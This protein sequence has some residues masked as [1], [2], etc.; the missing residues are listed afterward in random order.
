MSR[1]LPLSIILLAVT[2]CGHSPKSESGLRRFL[3]DELVEWM[4][5]RPSDAETFG[6]RVAATKP[7]LGY[8]IRSVVPIEPDPVVLPVEVM[9]HDSWREWPFYRVGVVLTFEA[10][11]GSPTEKTATYVAGWDAT[12]GRWHLRDE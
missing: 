1:S 2:G 7:P 8:E 11:A 9:K 10:T 12:A 5:G 3:D 4:A 6:F